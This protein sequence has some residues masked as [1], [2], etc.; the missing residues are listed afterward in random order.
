MTVF[1]A[2]HHKDEVNCIVLSPDEKTFASISA[3]ATMYVCDSET[4]HCI[5]GPFK[6]RNPDFSRLLDRADACFNP[7]GNLI[8]VKYCYYKTLSCP[9]I[10]WNIEKGEEVFQIESFDF[11][12]IHSGCNEGK[13]ASMHWIDEDGSSIRKMPSVHQRRPTRIMV[14]LWDIG[15]GISHR[16]FEMNGIT[17]AQFS[18][19]GK[20]LAAERQSESIV[21]LWNLE[22]GKITH[23]FL[24]PSDDL[25]SLHFS[26]TNYYLTAAFRTL[27]RKYL[28]RLDTQEMVSFDLDVKN[29]LL[30]VIHSSHINRIFVPRDETVEIWEVSTT[31]SNIIFK[32]E[33]LTVRRITSIC[34]SRDGHRLLVGS[35]DG[36]VRMLDLEDLRSNEPITQDD[37]DGQRI[38]A[39]SPSGKTVA[40]GS[41]QS[42]HIGLSGAATYIE[43]RD[44]ATWELVGPR[45]VEDGYAVAFSSDDNRI[46]VWSG[47]PVIIR[48]INH[49]K[50]RLS[51]DPCPGRSVYNKEAAFQTC[52]DLVICAKPFFDEISGL[53]QVW[54]VKDHT[55]CTFSLDINMDKDS[56]IFL[57]PDGLT[58]IILRPTSCYSWNH[59]TAQFDP[60][61]FADEAHLGGS[62][63]AYSPDGKFF[64]CRSPKDNDVRVWD[65]RTGQLCRKLTTMFDV[66]AIALSPA[67]NGISYGD[68]LI[69]LRDE[70]TGTT[71][72][73]DV[74]TGHLYAQRWDSGWPMAF[75]QDGTKLMSRHPT[76]IYDIADIAAKHRNA[77]HEYERV[78]EDGWMMGQDNEL[79]FWVPLENRE[80][81]CPS[82]VRTIGGRPT[83]VN[84]SKFKFGT[85]WAKCVDQE[86]LKELEERGK[87]VGKLLE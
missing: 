30:A 51:F 74:H 28:R 38:I 55:E 23:Q 17:V 72:L 44:T 52:N 22:D 87:W 82:Q 26:P 4:G 84:F 57:A 83:K 63:M 40:I 77:P 42:T 37:T 16:L 66:I 45:D 35:G 9:A 10:V 58:V 5:S 62:W 60:F 11:V 79:L 47:S 65:T 70:R 64:A 46:A 20:Y 34:P 32:T 73:F 36:S 78:Q 31:G 80:V 15:N 41:Q 59:D 25:S 27:F 53:L 43:L 18:P 7:D 50:N 85:E 14:K 86:W 8:L 19:N 39:L 49:P 21:E 13:I 24:H 2:E 67:L 3:R 71:T 75:I 81:L 56:D 1:V 33:P 68:R 29:I 76:R 54:K 61:H 12:F 69:A 6:L 48:D